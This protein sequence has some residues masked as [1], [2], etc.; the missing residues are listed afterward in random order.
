MRFLIITQKIDENDAVLGFMH[1]W[2][3]EFAK[4]S[5]GVVA[6]CLEKGKVDL[7]KNVRVFSLGKE[8]DADRRGQSRGQTRTRMKYL[9]R[10]VRYIVQT[11]KEYDTVFVHMNPEYIALG[12]LFW[13]LWGKTVVL[14]YAH[15]SVPWHLRVALRFA[16]IVFTSTESGFRLNSKKVRVVGQGIDV[17]KFKNQKSK[18]KIEDEAFKI[19]TVGRITPAKDYETLI[20]A[21]EIARAKIAQPIAVSIVGPTS[22]ASDELYLKNLKEKIDRKN[23]SEIF[24]FD[25]PIANK[26][27]P[28]RLN[29]ADL[30]VNMGHTGSLDKAVPEAM[31]SSLPILTCNEAFTE[32][33]GPFARVLMYPKRDSSALADK[34]VEMA[35]YSQE[36]RNELGER[37][38]NI[39]VQSHGLPAFVKKIKDEIIEFET[40]KK[41]FLKI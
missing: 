3:S 29:Q 31:S 8:Q 32:V 7:P 25:G 11:R 40:H 4:Q 2:I 17:E 1:G 20:D 15:K 30:F 38:R 39:V 18:I 34:I 5:D 6:L 12:G 37:L 10:F 19:M 23:L 13:K 36:E 26:D 35:G 22:L 24:T 27:L 33:L 21:V 16:D 41:Y 14:W 9:W 28:A